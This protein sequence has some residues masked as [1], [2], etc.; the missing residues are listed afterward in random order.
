MSP[1]LA[2]DCAIKNIG[3]SLVDKID[4]KYKVFGYGVINLNEI[5]ECEYSLCN[6]PSFYLSMDSIDMHITCCKGHKEYFKEYKLRKIKDAT[7][8]DFAKNII[9]KFNMFDEMDFNDII[10]ENQPSL[11]NPTVKSIQNFISMYFLIKNKN[12]KFQNP[13]A[14]TFNKKFDGKNKYKEGKMY[15]QKICEALIDK[16]KFDEIMLLDKVDDVF[17]SLTHAIYHLCDGKKPNEIMKL[18]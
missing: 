3:W 16:D 18:I 4:G 10:I 12:I 11:K 2:I 17:D 1:I 5:P 6:K 7:T 15:T 13:L 9:K 14:K 8:I